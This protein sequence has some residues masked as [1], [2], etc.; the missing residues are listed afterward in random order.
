MDGD[1]AKDHEY[2]Y[3]NVVVKS[4]LMHRIH[5]SELIIKLDDV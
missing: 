3:I 2:V 4:Y 5:P 1:M